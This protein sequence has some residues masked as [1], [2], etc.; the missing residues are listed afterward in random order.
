MEA[1]IFDSENYSWLKNPV[2]IQFGTTVTSIN[3]SVFSDCTSL[4]SVSMPNV[5]T[6]GGGAFNNISPS[7]EFKNQTTSKISGWF[8]SYVFGDYWGPVTVTCSNGSVHAEFDYSE[9]TWAIE[10]T[11]AQQ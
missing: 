11:P 9:Y 3:N 5:T 8:E 2:S 4:A 7:V 1:G 6:V 10:I